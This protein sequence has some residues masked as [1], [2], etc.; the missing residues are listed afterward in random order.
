[1]LAELY[2]QYYYMCLKLD[3][4]FI[5]FFIRFPHNLFI[6]NDDTDIEKSSRNVTKHL[7]DD[8]NAISNVIGWLYFAAWSVSFYPQ[9]WDNYRSKRYV[10]RELGG[11]QS[12]INLQ[13]SFISLMA[14]SSY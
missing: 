8:I 7:S 11:N 6:T 2:H 10:I 13:L 9:L 14:L 4:S 5:S 12:Y 3:E 1:M